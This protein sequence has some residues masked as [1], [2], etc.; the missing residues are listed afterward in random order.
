[1][2]IVRLARNHPLRD[3]N[4]RAA[5][6]SWRLFVDINDWNWAPKPDFD[7]AEAAV[8]ALASGA[9]DERTTAS[10]LNKFLRPIST[11]V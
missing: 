3:G 5:W 4:K 1:V 11:D 6:V 9:R 2:L 7:E 10:W 8:L